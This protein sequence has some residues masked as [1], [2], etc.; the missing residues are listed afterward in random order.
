M[1]GYTRR[2]ND[3]PDS[4]IM[5]HQIALPVPYNHGD[6]HEFGVNDSGSYP[7]QQQS[8]NAYTQQ[9]SS[10]YGHSSISPSTHHLS[11]HHSPGHSV[12]STPDHIPLQ[13]AMQ[14]MPHSRYLQSP[15]FLPLREA[16]TEADIESQ[17]SHN[18]STM[19][20]EA[21]IPPLDGFPNVR[22]FDQLMKSYVDDLSIKK[23]D[24][25]LI[26]ARRARNIKTVLMDPKDTAIESAQFRFWVK[27]MFKL[28]TVGSVTSDCA[29]M[30]C[31]EGKPVAIREKL[32]KILTRAHQQCQH[33][34]RDK[35]SAQVRQIY[36][37]VPKELISRFVKICPTC[38]VRR[39]G[40]RLTP[41]SSRRS[42]PRLEVASR[43][44]KLP[45]P[46]ISRRDSTLNGQVPIDRPQADYFTQ[47]NSHGTWLESQR[48]LQERQAMNT[49][50][51]RSFNSGAMGHLTST[52][53]GT[54]DSFHSDMPV[55][56]SQVTYTAGYP[57]A[58]GAPSHRE[59]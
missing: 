6:T 42:S 13:H 31:H 1:S 5:N 2:N 23:Q 26:H 40:S 3:G 19:L 32:F 49:G 51:V 27:K 50:H 46:P 10:P 45:S 34:G 53:P 22:E 41:P 33:G 9:F 29:K 44:P 11:P 52:L 24:K 20:S 47:F 48:S 8:F 16:I 38:Q 12:P 55:P 57:S 17:E 4:Y 15:G 7:F 35:T 18:E 36:S 37:W 14:Y 54:L 56:S 39:G 59:F 30:I 25:A 21:V 43:S 28:Q 58:H